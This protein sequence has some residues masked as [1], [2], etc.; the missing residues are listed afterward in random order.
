MTF[1]DGGDGSFLFRVI[2]SIC[3][4]SFFLKKKK[5]SAMG[6]HVNHLE[7]FSTSRM[8]AE[9]AAEAA[10]AKLEQTIALFGRYGEVPH[11]IHLQAEQ[12]AASTGK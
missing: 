9:A 3:I 2:Q 4:R 12:L 5:L 6:F 1:V 11:S 7:A 10:T 8:T